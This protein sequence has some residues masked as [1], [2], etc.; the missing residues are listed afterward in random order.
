MASKIVFQGKEYFHNAQI[1]K[2]EDLERLIGA[3][4]TPNSRLILVK[5]NQA[6]PIDGPFAAGETDRVH[7]VPKGTRK[8]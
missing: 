3:A 8:G 6:T 2:P 1:L 7:E 4:R 5:G